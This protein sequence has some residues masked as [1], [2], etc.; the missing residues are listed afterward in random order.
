MSRSR[1]L[2]AMTAA[3]VFGLILIAPIRAQQS[4]DGVEYSP[5]L[6][7]Y[8]VALANSGIASVRIDRADL[9][10]TADGWNGATTLIADDRTHQLDSLFVA[11]D[12]RRGGSDAISYIFDQAH[13]AALAFANPTGNATVTLPAAVTG[14]RIDASMGR[15]Q[16]EPSCPGPAVEKVPYTGVDP[17]ILDGLILGP[18]FGIGTPQADITHGGWLP[19]AFFDALEPN[20]SASILGVTF[21]FIFVNGGNPTDIDN[22][23]RADVAFRE[24]YFNSRFAWSEGP[25]R[26]R[27]IDID[28][29]ATHES[30]HA[31][32]LDHFG[33]V[34]LDNN[35]VIKYAPRAVMNAVYVSPFADLAGTDNASF[36]SIWASKK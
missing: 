5:T 11:R 23:G 10:V 34:F 31:F 32:G 25:S 33:K 3:M 22:N 36:C 9:L 18:P 1:Y 13:G 12:P 15:W 24:I 14:A 16:N 6:A 17:D 2:P 4:P 35:G 8:N 7:G 29:V 21:T 30:G 19:R 28:S 20:G 26:P 27:G